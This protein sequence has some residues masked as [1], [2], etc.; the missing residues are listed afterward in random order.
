MQ[1][2]QNLAYIRGHVAE[3]PA[4][5]HESHGIRYHVFVLATKRLSGAEDF[6]RVVAAED[7][8][9]AYPCHEGQRIVVDGS[10]RSFNNKSNVGSRLVITVLA[11]EISE[12]Y[13]PDDNRVQ[14]SGALCKAPIYRKTPLGRE[15]CDLIL[16]VNRPYGRADYLPCIVWGAGARQC[17]GC[18]VG[19]RLTLEGRIQSRQYIK[20]VD[21]TPIH[22]TAYEVSV[23][24][25][26]LGGDEHLEEFG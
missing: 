23:G 18:G 3:R 16:A 6:I 2:A 10:L 25:V 15:I 12:G 24:Q 1:T 20:M 5:S 19:D 21:G 14:L 13:E 8:F 4:F 17:A 7:L 26:T 9:F 11:R 22:K